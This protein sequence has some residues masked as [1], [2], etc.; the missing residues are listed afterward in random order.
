MPIK[1]IP[2]EDVKTEGLKNWS[3]ANLFRRKNL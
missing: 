2:Y 3:F 1:C